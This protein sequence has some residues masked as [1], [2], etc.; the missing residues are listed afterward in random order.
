[1]W[2]DVMGGMSKIA[3]RRERALHAAA[4]A[5]LLLWLLPTRASCSLPTVDGAWRTHSSKAAPCYN[6]A[7]LCLR[8][9]RR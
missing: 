1:M 4:V 3:G 9:S 5:L 2:R 7:T 8:G 6:L